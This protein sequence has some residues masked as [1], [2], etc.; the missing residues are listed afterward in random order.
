MGFIFVFVVLGIVAIIARVPIRQFIKAVREPFVIAFATVM[1]LLWIWMNKRK[2]E[3]NTVVKF[4]LGFLF[5]AGGFWIFYYTKFFADP[6][7]KT[8]LNL[9]CRDTD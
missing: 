2:I 5:L 8:S 6:S 7:G 1:G 3:P 9:L 4:G